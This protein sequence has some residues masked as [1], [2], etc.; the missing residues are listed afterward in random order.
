M[1]VLE[2]EELSN[3]QKFWDSVERSYLE[4]GQL[5]SP[6]VMWAFGVETVHRTTGERAEINLNV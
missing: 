2:K 3:V 4:S 6:T 5:R 1:G